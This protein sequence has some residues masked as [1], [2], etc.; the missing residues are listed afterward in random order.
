MNRRRRDPD[1]RCGAHARHTLMQ[2]GLAIA[3]CL[4][5]ASALAVSC[6]AST[7]GLA[8]GS[9]DVYAVGATNG[10]GTLTVSCSKVAGDPSNVTVNYTISLAT[11]SSGNYVQRQMKSGANTLGYN[12]YTSN[13]FS[14][15]WGNG[16]GSTATVAGNFHLTN[17]QPSQNNA[18]T[19]Y[20]RVPPLQ[21][22]AVASNYLDNITVTVT[23]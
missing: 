13:T 15:V 18:H 2:F 21:D 4:A 10:T 11:G 8:F 9:Y 22:A 19:V 1:A 7:P 17:G 5:A 23:Y 14:V 3:L 6:S 12:L 20:G 16:T